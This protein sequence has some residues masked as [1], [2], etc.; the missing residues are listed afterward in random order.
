MHDK[1]ETFTVFGDLRSLLIA[2]KGQEFG[3]VSRIRSDHGRKVQNS[4]FSTFCIQHGI[5]REF[6]AP[7]TLQQNGVVERKNR[8]V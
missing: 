5:K 8:V 1:L 4:D 6:S 3:G 2:D 7:K